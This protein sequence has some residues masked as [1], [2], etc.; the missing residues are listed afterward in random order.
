LYEYGV[1]GGNSSK[2]KRTYWIWDA[3]LQ[4]SFGGVGGYRTVSPN[5][6]NVS[7]PSYTVTPALPQGTTIE[8]Y[9]MINSGQAIMV[10]RRVANSSGNIVVKESHKLG[11][12]GNRL[13]LR[14]S[15]TEVG[16]INVDMYRANGSTLEFPM[17]G[18]VA[19][20]ADWY[21]AEPTDVYDVYKNNQFQENL[22]I[23]RRDNAG[24]L[25]YLGIES[26]PMPTANDTIF[27]PFYFTSNRGYALK[28]NAENMPAANLRA[29]LQDQFTGTET[30]VPM[31]GSDLVYPFTVTADAN[32]KALT[33]LR[34]VFRPSTITNTPDLFA[35][36]DIS[37]YPNPVVKGEGIN[38]QFRNTGTGRYNV[39]VYD[40]LGIKVHQT[41]VVHAGGNGVQRV[42]LPN[43]LSSGTYF[44]E[45]TDQKGQTGK[46]KVVIQ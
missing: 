41:I 12:K 33:R 22:S 9:L 26:R 25:R 39:Q 23:S 2:I 10:E 19:R 14:T 40:M 5:N 38:L 7:N 20:F 34:L 27:M 44:V 36:K 32:S 6:E 29:F 3:N 45:L 46:Q 16:K 15:N 30:E 11:N 21:D 13:N 37:I 28:F 24:V 1:E 8:D 4:T 18:V 42:Q 35:T 31:D 17:D 43:G